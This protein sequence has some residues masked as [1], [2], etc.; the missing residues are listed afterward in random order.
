MF[1]SRL[2]LFCLCLLSSSYL[3]AAEPNE[4]LTVSFA[5]E[6]NYYPFEYLNEKQELQG[7]DIDIANAICQA[8][9]LSCSFHPQ[10]FDSLLLTLQ[11]GR[12]DAV[13]AALDITD[14]RKEKVDFSDSYYKNPPVFVSKKSSSDDFSIAGKFI[15][16]KAN[17]SN[18]NYLIRYAKEDSFIISYLTVSDALID[19]KNG[20]IDGAFADHAVVADFLKQEDNEKYFSIRRIEDMFMRKFSEGYGIAVKK[21]NDQL[22]ERLNLGLKIIIENGTYQKIYDLYF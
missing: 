1:L 18:Q 12:F 2:S 5:T 8:V 4:P 10:S 13:I 6:S 16:V 14:E 9:N 22:R 19:L 20:K 7:F 17:T 15:G 3:S 21:G 11:F